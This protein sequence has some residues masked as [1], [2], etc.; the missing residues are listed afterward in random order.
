MIKIVLQICIET[1]LPQRVANGWV[2]CRR[3]HDCG[4]EFIEKS[5][6]CSC[7]KPGTDHGV[8]ASKS[9][10]EGGG[11]HESIIPLLF[12]GGNWFYHNL[13]SGRNRLNLTILI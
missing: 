9:S 12:R 10:Q 8:R 13:T 5:S 2:S 11:P 4:I 3:P 7:K 1:R 6:L